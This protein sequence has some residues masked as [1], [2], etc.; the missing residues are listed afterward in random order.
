MKSLVKK[1]VSWSWSRYAGYVQCPA[2]L[3]YRAIDKLQEP[4]SDAMAH[5]IEVHDTIADYIMMKRGRLTAQLNHC[6]ANFQDLRAMWKNRMKLAVKAM[7]PI[8]EEEWAFTKDWAR[9]G[10]KDWSGCAVRIKIDVGWWETPTRLRV[11][12]WKSGKYSEKNRE[13]YQQQLELYALAAF[14]IYPQL[15]EVVP[16][17]YYVEAG[18]KY[19]PA[20]EE[21]VFTRADVPRL[22][23]LWEKRVKPLLNDQT[24]SPRPGWYCPGCYFNKSTEY[25]WGKNKK[26]KPAG[27]CKF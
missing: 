19:P 16:D 5:G 27:P 8:V 1:L 13:E 25:G 20:G 10:W 3:K 4:K 24:F 7:A 22:K 12:D 26:T 9:T 23:K 21:I 2:Q 18:I 15:E 11:R 14:L 6:G 17:L